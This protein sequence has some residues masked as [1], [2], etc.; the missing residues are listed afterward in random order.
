MYI[1]HLIINMHWAASGKR[2]TQIEAAKL[3]DRPAYVFAIGVGSGVDV[4]E[5]NGISSDPDERFTIQVSSF[6][7]LNSDDIKQMLLKRACVGM[8]SE[9]VIAP[10]AF[11]TSSFV[12]YVLN[13]NSG[14]KK[15]LKETAATRVSSA[16]TSRKLTMSLT[17]CIC[18]LKS[19][20]VYDD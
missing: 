4:T 18:S 2:Q 15:L 17:N 12:L 10:M 8:F 6:K 13:K 5:L 3:K 1:Y 19:A 14:C 20:L 9:C 7:K 11:K 16:F